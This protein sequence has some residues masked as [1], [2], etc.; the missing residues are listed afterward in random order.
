METSVPV[1][2]PNIILTPEVPKSMPM[3]M[4]DSPILIY[5]D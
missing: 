2:V 3:N 4:V 1:F 5:I